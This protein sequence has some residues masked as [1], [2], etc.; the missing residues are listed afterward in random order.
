MRFS[1]QLE[2]YR[3][4]I[5]MFKF[6]M[7]AVEVITGTTLLL[8]SYAGLTGIVTRLTARELIEDPNDEFVRVMAEKMFAF[9]DHKTAFGAA[10]LALGCIKIIATIGF[11]RRRSW[12][13]LLLLAIVALAMPA[14]LYHLARSPGIFAAII[15]LLN[16]AVLGFLLRFRKQLSGSQDDGPLWRAFGRP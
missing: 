15:P 14:E 12:G 9:L 13:Y 2:K 5:A 6:F 3:F 4:I 16:V 10:L 1:E 11:L 7:G 8:A